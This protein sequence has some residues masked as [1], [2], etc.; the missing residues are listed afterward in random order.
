MAPLARFFLSRSLLASGFD[1]DKGER[2]NAQECACYHHS[3]LFFVEPTYLSESSIVS[4]ISYMPV[5]YVQFRI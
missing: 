5:P 4:R 2:Q 1:L 3:M